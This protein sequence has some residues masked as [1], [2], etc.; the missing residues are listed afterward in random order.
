MTEEQQSLVPG[1]DAT[2][3]LGA[4]SQAK[5]YPPN[6][7][8]WAVVVGISKYVHAP[9][10]LDYANRDAVEF[11]KTIRADAGGRFQEVK[12][13]ID[14]A[15]TLGNINR[16]L[17]SFLKKPDID[18]VVLLYFACHGA[19]DP[20]RPE[21]IYLL[22]HDT[23][24]D[25]IAATALPIREIREALKVTIRAE[26]IVILADTCHSGGLDVF[27]G[28]RGIDQSGVVNTYLQDLS[29]S[30][31]G[32]ALLTSAAANETAVEDRRW[33]GGHGVFT[34]FLL[35]GMRGKADGYGG[36]PRDGK[37]AVR[38]LFEYV[39]D[40]VKKETGDAQ[41]PVIGPEAFDPNLPMAIT[42]QIDAGELCKLGEQTEHLA[43]LLDDPMRYRAAATLY[44]DAYE[45]ASRVEGRAPGAEVGLARN[46]IEA[47]E[48]DEAT[49]TL[50]KLIERDG[51]EADPEALLWLGIGRAIQR[52]Q[53]AGEPLRTFA[54]QNTLHEASAWAA[55]YAAATTGSG[56]RRAL[57]IGINAYASETIPPLEGCVNDVH[58]IR[59]VLKN[60]FHLEDANTNVLL[61]ESATRQGILDALADLGR[62]SADEDQL[63]VFYSGHSIPE[64]SPE[65]F[66]LPTADDMY[67]VVHDTV[68]R[69]GR[70]D[71][72]I[73]SAELHAA[74]KALPARNKVLVLD[75]HARRRFN[76]LAEQDGDYQVLL[77]SDLA[78]TTDE[79]R[80]TI[81]GKQ[82]TAGA[83]TSALVQ[84]LESASEYITCGALLQGTIAKLGDQVRKQ[85]PLVIGDREVPFFAPD[86]VLLKGFLFSRR[87]SFA[88]LT[89]RV[90]E[91]RYA[92]Y[93]A[94]FDFPFP[95]LHYSF[96]LAFARKGLLERG[97]AALN[98]ALVESSGRGADARLALARAEIQAGAYAAAHQNLGLVRQE[99]PKNQAVRATRAET[100]AQRMAA[101]GRHALLVGVSRYAL[102]D[103]PFVT[104]AD[105]DVE[106]MRRALIEDLGFS[107]SNITILL[108][109]SATR[110]SVIDGLRQL[111]EKS[112][113]EPS[114]F[115]FAGLGSFTSRFKL[116]VLGWNSRLPDVNDIELAEM[117][118]LFGGSADSITI[119]DTS[120][121]FGGSRSISPE[122]F[123]RAQTR[124]IT[125]LLPGLLQSLS[126]PVKF[127]GPTPGVT[128]LAG[129]ALPS[130]QVSDRES[131][132]I[133]F[134]LGAADPVA[135]VQQ[136]VVHGS[137]ASALVRGLKDLPVDQ[138]SY[139]QWFKAAS[140]HMGEGEELR[141][142]GG[143]LDEPRFESVTL[144][145]NAL[146]EMTAIEQSPIDELIEALVRVV[147]ERER[148]GDF[149]P[150]GRLDLGIA[151]SVKGAL[152]RAVAPL[153]R[154]VS[155]YSNEL[156][157]NQEQARDARAKDW[158]REARFQLG[159]VL[160]EEKQQL[161][162]AVSELEQVVKD[163]PQHAAALF[164]YG[165]AIRAMVERDTLTEASN[166]LRLYLQLGAPLGE[167]ND[168]REFLGSR[169]HS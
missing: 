136:A 166:A 60:R 83:F 5:V 77:A 124:G 31:G 104:G 134:T 157:M 46:L 108:N 47:G 51:G 85:T 72:G 27:A 168:V 89:T 50:T 88:G 65:A 39:R 68:A 84:Y 155:L 107:A 145:R 151:Y 117:R 12:E 73:F 58:L 103:L 35:E 6:V 86:D 44:A 1:G 2:R 147:D 163:N 122:R 52:R 167:E 37:V 119:L 142:L 81:K 111:G 64:S 63:L 97:R 131:E 112:R 67:L 129:H 22:M 3:D 16:A 40:M 101:A 106:L 90:L 149:H 156:V 114:L 96:G 45:F 133:E 9:W 14:E 79:T 76:D 41:H 21:N 123:R 43:R 93:S 36:K 11:A 120:W 128:V 139:R 18:D 126:D 69:E 66:G 25:E 141:A 165:Q 113:E 10:N 158:L 70:I 8:G 140:R 115:Y 62:R 100:S 105:S 132:G 154:A 30:H 87:L 95:A 7:K 137:L 75:T 82:A 49:R 148:R 146:A 121:R 116:T 161:G 94:R 91:R 98:Q 29:Q 143:A 152:A 80:T 135:M 26:R 160:Y 23:E 24:P 92:Q 78:Q 110:A 20:D 159:R 34:H 42:G 4:P 28:R 109:E 102:P 19:P 33:G 53:D 99:L 150:R 71:R 153:E 48:I 130:S 56:E 144:R 54:E 125:S 169:K 118:E 59:D 164:Y 138:P 32:V 61:D 74:M 17:K 162:R 57:C 55:R 38:E 13:L 15:A 127:F